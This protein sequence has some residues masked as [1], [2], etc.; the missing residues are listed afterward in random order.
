MFF[1]EQNLNLQQSQFIEIII[2]YIVKKGTLERQVLQQDPFS[3]VGGIM[4]VFKDQ[5]PKARGILD[6]L[7]RINRNAEEIS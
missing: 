3:S 5:L 1:S 2:D 4:V 6:I 7:E